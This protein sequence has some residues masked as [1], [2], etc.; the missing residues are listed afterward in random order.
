MDDGVLDVV[1]STTLLPPSSSVV[2]VGTFKFF[3]NQWRSITCNSFALNMVNGHQLQLRCHPPFFYNFKWFK[4][5]A[6]TAHDPIIQKE[7]GELL[8]KGAIDQLT[9]GASFDYLCIIVVLKYTG[10]L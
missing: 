9:G 4:T 6:A 8:A 2:Q 10:G 7:V 1:Q 5:K 3:L